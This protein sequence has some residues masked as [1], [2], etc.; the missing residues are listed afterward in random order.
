M[1]ISD[2]SFPTRAHAAIDREIALLETTEAR[3]SKCVELSPDFAMRQEVEDNGTFL[4]ARWTDRVGGKRGLKVPAG[5][6]ARDDL[7]WVCL[8][9]MLVRDL[10]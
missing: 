2:H 3:V 9:R 1:N 4:V 8:Y 10:P 6:D 7:A 5:D